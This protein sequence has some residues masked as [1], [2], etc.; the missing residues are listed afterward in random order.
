MKDLAVKTALCSNRGLNLNQ[1]ADYPGDQ[2][3]LETRQENFPK[4]RKKCLN[5]S[6]LKKTVNLDFAAKD[7][8]NVLFLKVSSTVI[9]EAPCTKNMILKK[10]WAHLQIGLHCENKLDER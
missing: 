6:F 4:S 2:I 5:G 8:V 3:F 7:Y 9:L 1:R 10:Q